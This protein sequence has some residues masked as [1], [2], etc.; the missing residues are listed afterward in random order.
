[1]SASLPQP[2]P[3]QKTGMKL[4]PRYGAEGP[5]REAAVRVWNIRQGLVG[6]AELTENINTA[7]QE[8]DWK[9]LGYGSWQDYTASEF[10]EPLPLT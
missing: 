1:M 7:Y 10:G 5:K 2:V 9:V 8:E 3:V 6:L 4:T